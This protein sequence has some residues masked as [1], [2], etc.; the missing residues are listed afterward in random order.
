MRQLPVRANL[1]QKGKPVQS[2]PAQIWE[3]RAVPN[4]IV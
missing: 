3:V 2:I 4:G 1:Q